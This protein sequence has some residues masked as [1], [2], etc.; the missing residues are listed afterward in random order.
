MS[1]RIGN[2]D[3][4]C[5]KDILMKQSGKQLSSFFGIEN[6]LCAV[7]ELKIIFLCSL[8]AMYATDF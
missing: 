8:R 6:S 3:M 7:T 5:V 2:P 1:Y 4:A